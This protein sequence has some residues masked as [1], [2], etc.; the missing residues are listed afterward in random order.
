[1]TLMALAVG[2]LIKVLLPRANAM[3]IVFM[4]M[5]LGLM[6]AMVIQVMKVRM[7]VVQ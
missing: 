2:V 4:V 6:F 3:A 1:M 7:L 5:G